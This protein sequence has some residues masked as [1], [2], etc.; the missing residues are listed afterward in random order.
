MSLMKRMVELAKPGPSEWWP[1]YDLPDDWTAWMHTDFP[2]VEQYEDGGTMVVKAELP[3][4]D[5]D[6]DVEITMSDHT[7]RIKAE[8][9]REARSETATG[10][11]SEFHYGSYVRSVA[12]PAGATPDDVKASYSHGILEVRVPVSA[13]LAESRKIPVLTT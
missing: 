3:G 7:L 2:A 13:E 6:K 10:Y 11:R 5:P 8:R 4:I 1:T 12:L 9:H